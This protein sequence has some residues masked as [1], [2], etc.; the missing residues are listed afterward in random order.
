MRPAS[1]AGSILGC[2]C[3]R[4]SSARDAPTTL[5][6]ARRMPGSRFKIRLVKRSG[7]VPLSDWGAAW[8][9]GSGLGRDSVTRSDHL[10]GH[11]EAATMRVAI[12][13]E[14]QSTLCSNCGKYYAGPTRFCPNCAHP[15]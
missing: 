5:L 13:R 2:G 14:R 1:A 8:V 11:W 15:T 4:R 9:Y 3:T 10:L 6:R 7:Q 12:E